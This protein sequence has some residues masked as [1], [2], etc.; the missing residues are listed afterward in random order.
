MGLSQTLAMPKLENL[1]KALVFKFVSF[2][3]AVDDSKWNV[4]LF[5]FEADEEWRR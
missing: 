4:V 5:Q 2:L 1:S 3:R